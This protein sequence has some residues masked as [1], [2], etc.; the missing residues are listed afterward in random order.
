[1]KQ[2]RLFVRAGLMA[3]ILVSTTFISW[4]LH[5]R[6]QG[7]GLSYDDG[8]SLWSDK[9]KQ[10]YEDIDKATVFIGSS[11][12]KYD[13]D[14]HTWQNITG[15]HVIQLANVGSSPRLILD[16]LAEDT[17]FKGKLVIDVTEFL[18]FTQAP[19]VDKTPSENLDYYK[20]ETPAQKFSFALNQVLE[21]NLYLLD[22]EEYSLNALL[23]GLK[24]PNRTD[25]YEFPDFPAGFTP[26][27]FDRQSYMTDRLVN[28]TNLLNK[29]TAVW[30]M[31]GKMAEKMPPMSDAAID[32]IM[33]SVKAACD[34][35]RAR[36]GQIIFVRTPSS[37]PLLAMER[38]AFPREKFWNRLLAV[39]GCQGIHFEDYPPIAKFECPEFSHLSVTQAVSFTKAF[40]TIL[41]NKGWK[42]PSHNNI[43]ASTNPKI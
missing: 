10:V 19:Y 24:I 27:T 17:N 40:I 13:L 37:G 21:S 43:T 14:I 31:L 6:S 41:E 5:L 29:V 23:S 32:G 3:V 33:M 9:R 36:G 15:D 39:T 30:G 4:E 18:F 34:K 38:M 26:V 20:K 1:M 22:K 7:R 35:I 16:N 2:K 12:I 42:F 11:R 8:G 25:V 28:D